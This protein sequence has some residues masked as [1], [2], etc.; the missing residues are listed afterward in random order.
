MVCV[1]TKASLSARLTERQSLL[2]SFPLRH[3]QFPICNYAH[4]DRYANRTFHSI[5]LLETQIL[6][7]GT[8]AIK[9]IY[10]PSQHIR[11]NIPTPNPQHTHL[12]ALSQL[13]HLTHHRNKNQHR[14][15]KWYISF[16]ILRRQVARLLPVVPEYVIES[17]SRGKVKGKAR[18][19][20]ERQE[21][22]LQGLVK[23]IAEGVV[24]GCYL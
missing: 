9:A 23:F 6:G 11:M 15:S 16:G 17:Q 1:C 5:N 13:L 22:E 19:R 21:R 18:E 10:E 3:S 4:D 20:K 8:R 2:I 7:K 14:L 12:V 24:P